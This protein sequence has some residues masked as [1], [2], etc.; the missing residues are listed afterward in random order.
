MA[1]K[2]FSNKKDFKPRLQAGVTLIEMLV[3]VGII[4]LMSAVMMF[5]YSD[6]STNVSVRNLSQEIALSVRKAQTY[7]TSVRTLEGSGLPSDTFQGYG[8]SF[9]DSSTDPKNNLTPWNRQ[10]ILFADTD[11]DIPVP[12]Q[13]SKYDSLGASNCGNPSSSNGEC[14]ES[15]GIVSADKIDS[16]CIDNKPCVKGTRVDITFRRPSPDA[17]IC[18]VTP[19]ATCQ[20]I[21]YVTVNLLSAKGLKRSVQIWNTGQIAVK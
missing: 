3:V 15:F 5:N 12:P 16:I 20:N 21:S 9:S 4:A 11:T 13:I 1:I 2:F 6:F 17:I 18:Q 19:T 10:F 14:L 7:A 8:I